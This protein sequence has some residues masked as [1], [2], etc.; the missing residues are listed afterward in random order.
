VERLKFIVSAQ[1]QQTSGEIAS[2]R[3]PALSEN[4]AGEA[5]REI[6]I[7]SNRG[8]DKILA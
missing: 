6:C 4:A 1:G 3:I 2:R 8:T 7:H 5:A